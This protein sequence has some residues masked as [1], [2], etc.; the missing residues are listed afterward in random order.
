MLHLGDVQLAAALCHPLIPTCSMLRR[1]S[2][3]PHITADLPRTPQ[4]IFQWWLPPSHLILQS[5]GL[6]HPQLCCSGD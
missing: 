1:V 5:V 6:L 3:G 4:S 2:P